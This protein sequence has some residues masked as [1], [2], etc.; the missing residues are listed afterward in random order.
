A[1]ANIIAKDANV[2]L[3]GLKDVT[4]QE[5]SSDVS[6]VWYILAALII[7][8]LM[9]CYPL[10]WIPGGLGGYGRDG[11]GGGGVSG[12]GFGGGGFGGG[13][14]GGGGFGGFGGGF[15][16]GGGAGGRF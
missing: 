12:G 2:T 5:G 14:F 7:L 4:F 1:V 3:D 10:I 13:G 16:G 9:S 15:S 11:F 8:I 6:A